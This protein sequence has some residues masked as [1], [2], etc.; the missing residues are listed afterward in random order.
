MN[1]SEILNM[2]K[3]VKVFLVLSVIALA[4][5]VTSQFK[6]Y[7]NTLAVSGPCYFNLNIKSFNGEGTTAIRTKQN[8]IHQTIVGVTVNPVRDLDVRILG[9]ESN[10]SPF[11][12]TAWGVLRNGV[13]I[14]TARTWVDPQLGA[15]EVGK[16]YITFIDGRTYYLTDTRTTGTWNVN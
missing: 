9:Y 5:I 15:L 10:G 12:A 14:S 6:L 4:T 8:Y 3:S 13:D 16:D 2:K 1:L 7:A 11:Y